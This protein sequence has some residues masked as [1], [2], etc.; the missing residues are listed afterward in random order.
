MDKILI[1]GADGQ[2]GQCLRT[3]AE[4][5]GI[6]NVFYAAQADAD[7]LD[8]QQLSALF[9]KEHPTHVINCAAYT[10]V[11]NAEDEHE[12]AAAVNN[13]GAANVAA[14]CNDHNAILIHISTDFVFEG[15]AVKLLTEDDVTAPI[16]V[17]GQTKL[18]GELSI[19]S[20]FEN[21]YILRTSWLYSEHGNNFVKTMLKL[22]ETR[23]ELNVIADQVGTPTYAIDLA[24][25]IFDIVAFKKEAF[26]IYHF[27]N[28]GVT[29]W[30]DFAQAIFELS[31]RNVR[32]NPIPGTAY[33]TKARRPLFSV[34]DKSKIKETFG[35]DVPYWRES[36]EKCLGKLN[37][38][39]G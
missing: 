30:F 10:A 28:E 38:K 22:A 7:I 20:I 24:N 37:S 5:R 34:M 26:G 36:L 2:L 39:P 25:V 18:D 29:S 4:L 33:P 23:P 14:L 15:N 35:V 1:I 6:E 27:S 21:Y 19:A 9:E 13:T 31:G 11:D 16:S 32:V 17:Y 8:I 3:V 12:L